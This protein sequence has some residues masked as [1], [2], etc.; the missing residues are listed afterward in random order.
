MAYD[1]SKSGFIKEYVDEMTDNIS[2]MR[3]NWDSNKIRAYVEKKLYAQVQNPRIVMDNNVLHENRE[4]TM[5]SVLD[6]IKD[7]KPIIAGNAT[8][9]KNQ[10]EAINPIAKM[11]DGMADRR[12]AFKKAMFSI[13][14]FE[15]TEY[16]DL[17]LKQA[18]EK[19]NMN[20]YYGAS[21]SPWSAFFSQWSGARLGRL[22]LP[23]R[24]RIE[25]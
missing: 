14:D 10:N 7:R 24:R 11:L 6:W 8:F 2:R 9:Y 21:G 18:N 4:A 20:S 23:I 1:Y 19:V 22:W 25:K 3:P 15:S 16:K 17:D 12:K 5:I 13:D